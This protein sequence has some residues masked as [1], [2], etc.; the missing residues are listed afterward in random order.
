MVIGTPLKAFFLSCLIFAGTARAQDGIQFESGTWSQVK[1]KAQREKKVIFV[2]V[3]TSWCIP[4]KKMV[5]EVFVL[6][7]VGQRF[8]K[9]FINYKIDAEKGEEK[10]ASNLL[11]KGEIDVKPPYAKF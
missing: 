6:P 5:K 9:D 7:E 8:N 11:N 10:A 3:Y 4:C 1:E 2:D